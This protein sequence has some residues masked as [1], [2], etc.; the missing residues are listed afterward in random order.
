[1]IQS[2]DIGRMSAANGCHPDNLP[3]QE[4]HTLIRSQNPGLCHLMVF[5]HCE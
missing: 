2:V 5:V 3:L 4:F 1:M